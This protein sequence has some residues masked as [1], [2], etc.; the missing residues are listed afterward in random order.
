MS[1]ELSVLSIAVEFYSTSRTVDGVKVLS[2]EMLPSHVFSQCML[3]LR[4]YLT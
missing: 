3:I 2:L 4:D 1:A